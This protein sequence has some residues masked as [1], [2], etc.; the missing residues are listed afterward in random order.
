MGPDLAH[1][2]ARTLAELVTGLWNHLPQMADRFA[3]D[4][5][6]P[7]RL[8]SWEAAD[9]MA[10]LFWAGS[11]TPSGSP[12][13]GSALFA[14]RQCILCHR[15]GSVGG[16]L[17]PALDGRG[18]WASSIDL[19]A[20]L[21][22]H[23]PTMT[24]EMR[25]RRVAPPPLGRREI[26]D[27]LAFFGTAGDDPPP[28]PVYALGGATDRGRVL[29]RE[30]GCIRCHRA[31]G[32]GGSVG[33]DLTAVAPRDPVAFAAAMWNKASTM[34]GAMEA[35]G[36]TA[37]RF[38]GAEM[39]DLV[40]YLGALQYLAGAGSASRGRVAA[41]PAGCGGCHGRDAPALSPLGTRSAAIAALWNH[42]ALPTET[43]RRQ[44]RRLT[45]AQV[46]DLMAYLETRERRP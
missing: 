13:V 23:A 40:A 24:A 12:E 25:S 35:A 29:F 3:D 7:P 15:V 36:V 17:G 33:P 10:F 11:G 46:A 8:D 39:A 1:R 4:G 37:P 43:F 45:T 34:V 38:T 5:V 26:E 21:W 42:V 22:N 31:G 9:L 28:E 19:A 2:S 20:A 32:E 18:A 41:G 14:S 16:V 30:R 6:A 44:W 27:L